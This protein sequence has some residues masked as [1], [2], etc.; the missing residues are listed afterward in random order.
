MLA[1]I[2]MTMTILPDTSLAAT[3]ELNILNKSALEKIKTSADST[4]KGKLNVLYLDLLLSQEQNQAW[5]EKIKNLHY[6][7]EENL[8]L[9]LQQIKG[10]DIA[11]IDK[12]KAELEKTKERYKPVFKAYKAIN[13][14]LGS[15]AKGIRVAVQLAR[16]DIENKEDGLRKAKDAAAKTIKKIRTILAGIEPMKVQIKAAK[17]NINAH[18]THVT[19]AGKSFNQAVKKNDVKNALE[20]LTLLAS[21]SRQIVV[22]KQN[23]HTLEKK[24]TDIL[25]KAKTLIPAKGLDTAHDHG[26]FIASNRSHFLLKSPLSH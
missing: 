25:I 6:K 18:K 7:N 11:K 13:P 23:I 22:Q 3:S 15:Q 8:I 19:H 12:L 21:H 14:L 24:I 20:G 17:S 26:Y 10:I 16:I 9:L 5:E 2:L 1:M 4:I